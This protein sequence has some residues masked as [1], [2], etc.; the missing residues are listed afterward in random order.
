[1]VLYTICTPARARVSKLAASSRQ[2]PRRR[3]GGGGTY[4]LVLQYRSTRQFYTLKSRHPVCC[5]YASE[6]LITSFSSSTLPVAR[7]PHNQHV[8]DS[9][10]PFCSMIWRRFPILSGFN[11]FEAPNPL[12]IL[13]PSNFVPKNGF[14]L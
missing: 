14:Q 8:S 10:L 9:N 4:S 13:I 12:P 6:C 5:C 1:M 11:P 7:N 2:W 3:W